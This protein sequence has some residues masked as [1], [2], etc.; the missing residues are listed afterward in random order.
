M[1]GGLRMGFIKEEFIMGSNAPNESSKIAKIYLDGGYLVYDHLSNYV[2]KI[3]YPVS[4]KPVQVLFSDVGYV[5]LLL[6]NG[7]EEP[8]DLNGILTILDLPLQTENV[9]VE[10]L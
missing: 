7:E 6:D 8:F 1:I 5:H 10:V 9:P 4:F 3:W 2:K